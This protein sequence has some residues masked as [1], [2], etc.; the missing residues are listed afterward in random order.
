MSEGVLDE[1]IREV[2]EAFGLPLD[3][4]HR[5]RLMEFLTSRWGVGL[6]RDFYRERMARWPG[7]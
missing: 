4:A 3:R 2:I 7:N 1:A 5:R 6:I